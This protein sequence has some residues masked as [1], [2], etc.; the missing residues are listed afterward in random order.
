MLLN[1]KV[2][3]IIHAGDAGREGELII[4]NIIH[5]S[6]VKKPMKRL[7]I[8]S[9]TKNAIVEGFQSLLNEEDTRNLYYEAYSR[10]CADWIVGM[11][12]SRI[13]S[14]LLKE[15]GIHDVF[16]AGRVQ[17]P[18]LALIVKRENEIENFVS[19]PFWEV[20]GKFQMNGEVYEGTWEKDGESRVDSKELAERI[21][22]FCHT[23]MAEVGDVEK[24]RKEYL[25]PL[26]FNLSNLQSTAN[27]LYKMSPKHVLDIAQSLYQ[28]GIISY[29][30]SDSTVVTKGEAEAFPAI[31]EKLSKLEAFSSYFPLPKETITTDKRFV[32]DKKVTDHYA[33][34]PTEQV[35]NLTNFKR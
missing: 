28:K 30:R 23:K 18:T 15:K 35:T 13:Y 2:T 1:H 21:A 3:E 5:Q 17:T 29:P 14:I 20:L 24:E 6:G 26:L 16:S 11:N 22:A 32:N 4:R 10:A 19:K 31:L 25:A 27:S 9:L 8:S 33:I 7:W 34:I 12:A